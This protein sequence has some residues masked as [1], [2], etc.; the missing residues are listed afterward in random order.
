MKKILLILVLLISTS[1]FAQSEDIQDGPFTRTISQKDLPIGKSF[2]VIPL[3][4]TVSFAGIID[5]ITISYMPINTP[6][7]LKVEGVESRKF[8]IY[9]GKN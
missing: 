6:F 8:N 9:N 2:L 1:V 4:G 7:I 5:E 3:D